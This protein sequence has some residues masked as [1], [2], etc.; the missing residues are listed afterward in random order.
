MSEDTYW[1]VGVDLPD[2]HPWQ[3]CGSMHGPLQRFDDESLVLPKNSGSSL[4]LECSNFNNVIVEVVELHG[5]VEL[6]ELHGI[7]VMVRLCKQGLFQ[8]LITFSL[9]I[10]SWS[11][12]YPTAKGMIKA[13]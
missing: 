5:I 8:G 12:M 1:S 10:T 11:P 7:V 3:L 6:V 9:A 2:P 4:G 13:Y